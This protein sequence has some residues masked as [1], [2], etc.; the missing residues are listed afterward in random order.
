[1]K[2]LLDLITEQYRKPD[3]IPYIFEVGQTVRVCVNVISDGQTPK[4]WASACEF[5]EH[6]LDLRYAKRNL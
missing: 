6:E 2:S 1:M 5:A 4:H 3:P